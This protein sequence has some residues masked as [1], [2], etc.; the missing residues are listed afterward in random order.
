M[1][2]VLTNL[3]SLFDDFRS[4]ERQMDELVGRSSWPVGIRSVSRNAWPAA[5]VGATPEMVNVY[6]FAAGL[7]PASID[8][9]IQQNLLTVS[10]TRPLPS[11]D[12]AAYYRQERFGGEFRRAFTL[13]ED[14]D[15]DKVEA[16]Y[17]D[18]LLTV[19]VRR[20][21]AV[22]PRQIRVG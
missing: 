8:V 7:D 16:S 17:R 21:Q 1:F 5:N 13:P 19:C 10:G 6:L 12:G 3:E 9:S 18:G 2:G 4:I 22:L 20:R 15:P 11:K 14:V